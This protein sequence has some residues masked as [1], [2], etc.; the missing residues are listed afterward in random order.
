MKLKCYC[1]GEPL[2]G[3]FALVSMQDETE[4]VFVMS[5]EHV[6]RASD[7]VFA[8]TVREQ[9]EKYERDIP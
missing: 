5:K 9:K 2:S 7:M 4:R 3:T 1:C 8:M 6:K